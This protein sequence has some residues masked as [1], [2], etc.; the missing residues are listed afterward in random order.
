MPQLPSFS[1][2][3]ADIYFIANSPSSFYK[4]MRENYFIKT[5]LAVIPSS[6][7]IEEFNKRVKEPVNTSKEI[8]NIYA[9]F[10]ALTL[11]EPNEVKQFF[12]DATKI[13]F[14]WFAEIA[15]YYLQNPTA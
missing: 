6:E 12:E 1:N 10:I 3:L 2:E 13:K 11:K 8:A 9:I 5:K 15:K 4:M 7:L 14:E